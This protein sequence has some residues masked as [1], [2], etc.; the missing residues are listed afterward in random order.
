MSPLGLLVYL[1]SQGVQLSSDGES[2][3]YE[4]PERGG[5]H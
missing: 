5:P 3:H 1:E 2:I 4:G